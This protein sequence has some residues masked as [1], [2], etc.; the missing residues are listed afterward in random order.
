MFADAPTQPTRRT[1]TRPGPRG[2]KAHPALPPGRLSVAEWMIG[3]S[4]FLA[5]AGV[6]VWQNSRL[7]VLWDLS[8]ILESAARISLGDMPYCDFPLPYAPLTFLLQAALMK[9]TGHVFFHHVMYCAVVGGAA[10]V[11]TWR[12][13]LNL[14]RGVLVAAPLAAGLLS[15]PMVVLGI[16]CIFPHPFYDSDCTFAILACILLLQQA[17]RRGFPRLRAFLTGTALV[18]PLFIKQN[19]GLAFLVCAVAALLVLVVIARRCDHSAAGY[20]WTIAG[21]GAGLLAAV[22]IIH[23]T[24][25]LTNYLH[26]TIQFAAARRLPMLADL[27]AIYQNRILWLWSAAF[28]IGAALLR[29]GNHNPRLARWAIAFLSL[30]FVW[31][32]VCRFVEE[33]ATGRAEQLLLLWPFGLIACF[34]V[35]VWNA[36]QASGV[37]LVLPFLLIGTIHGAFL[38]QQLWGSTYALWPLLVIL[39]AITFTALAERIAPP[40]TWNAVPLSGVVAVCLM[41]SGGY[42]AW[43]HERLD[44]ADLSEGIMVHSTLPAL[45]GLSVRGD[46]IPDFEELVGFSEREIPE[47][48]GLLMIPGEDLFY[49]TTGRRPRFPVVM[50][51]HTI[52][53]YSPEAILKLARSRNIGWLVVKRDLQ[54]RAD[55]VERKERMLELLRQEFEPHESLRNYDV[56]RRRQGDS[57]APD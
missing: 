4:L 25:G 27:A 40:A 13:V 53:P 32:L 30:P 16:Y 17:E 51:D 48:D 22:W 39:I 9:L 55:P 38:S 45:R 49:F 11:L 21:T 26:W 34:I 36:R 8:Y 23:L 1:P 44:Y 28:L 47:D 15:A 43:S 42:Y 10:T 6:V 57:S 52:N 35:A 33:D 46:W 56:Y 12:I 31:V 7:G 24:A 5:T 37:R 14:L 19:V 29:K 41:V 3:A 50:F 54:L 2:R 20:A 18:L